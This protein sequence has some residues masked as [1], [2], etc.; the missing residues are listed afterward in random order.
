MSQPECTCPVCGHKVDDI[1]ITILPERGMII[2]GG[3]FAVVQPGEM[4][5][6][7]RLC[8]VFPRVLTKEAALDWLYQL[9]P[10][11]AAEMRIIDVYVCK[12]RKKLN[13]L[14]VRIDTAWGKGYA[15][16]MKERPRIVEELAA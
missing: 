11:G 4:L 7:Q 1:P 5:L 8:E 12:M 10:D 2:A 6:L 16:G 14:G 9:N 3:K 13:P 15:L